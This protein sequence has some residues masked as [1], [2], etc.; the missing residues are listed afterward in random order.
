MWVIFSLIFLGLL[1]LG[2]IA[3]CLFFKIFN[4]I[5]IEDVKTKNKIKK[6]EKESEETE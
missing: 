1:I 5:K 6:L 4:Y 2:T 3:A